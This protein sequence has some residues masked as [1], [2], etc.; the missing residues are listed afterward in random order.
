M[1]VPETPTESPS[2]IADSPSDKGRESKRPGRAWRRWTAMV[3]L[4]LA[5]LI[6]PFAVLGTWVKANIFSTSGYVNTVAPLASNPTIQE[7]TAKKLTDQLFSKF[8]VE[9]EIKGALPAQLA[10]LAGPITDRLQA[11]TQEVAQKLLE[12]QQFQAIWT[13]GNQVAHETI[14]KFLK[15]DSKVKLG[16]NGTIVLDLS[17]ISTKLADRL[18]QAGLPISDATMAS[19][20][21]GEIPIA[22]ATTLNSI[23]GLLTTVNRVFIVLPI[24]VFIFLVGAFF[25]YP[26]RW[27]ILGRIGIGIAV[28]MALMAIAMAAVRTVLLSKTAAA[29]GSKDVAGAFWSTLTRDMRAAVIG[30]FC[31]GILLLIVAMLQRR[32]TTARMAAG[33]AGRGW[34]FGR[35]GEWLARH[36]T[37]VSIGILLVGFLVLVLWS[38]P[39]GWTIFVIGLIVAVLE[40]IV[41]FIALTTNRLIKSRESQGE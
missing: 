6:L 16:E 35:V 41:Q 40:F 34:D 33:A 39:N 28:V 7:A 27:R 9:S 30:L 26:G 14:V 1:D 11:R 31:L 19:L 36:R 22:K 18:K 2:E 32:G 37:W 24:L 12:T 17:G 8:D 20:D 25:L 4:V 13:K 38:S 10:V 3:L 15:G 29:G 23:K 5:C 21:K